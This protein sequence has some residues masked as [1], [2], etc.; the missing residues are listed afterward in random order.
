M[1]QCSK[2]FERRHKDEARSVDSGLTQVDDAISRIP[3]IQRKAKNARNSLAPINRFPPE[4]LALVAAFFESGR[5]L[6][7]ATAVCRHWRVALLSFPRLWNTIR[8]SN[9]RQFNAYLERSK[10]VPLAV[11]FYK[12]HHRQLRSLVPHTSRLV[13]LT[14][15]VSGSSDFG[16]IARHLRNSIPTLR[17]YTILGSHG[18]ERLELPSGI[19]NNHFMHVRELHLENISSLRAPLAFP[20]VT[21]LTWHV[22]PGRHGPVQLSELLGTLELLPALEKVD[23]VFW[24]SWDTGIDL[25]SRVVTLQ[26]VR[27]MCLRCS[28]DRGEGIPHILGFLE[29]PNLTSLVVDTAPRY[30]SLFPVLPFTPFRKHLP[31]LAKLPEMEVHIHEDDRIR[32]RS[33][34]QATLECRSVGGP[35]G[36]MAYRYDRQLWGG[37]PLHSVRRL[38]VTL[39]KQECG[40]ETTWLVCLLRDLGLLEHL[41]LEG[42]CG[43]ALRCLRRAMMRREILLGTKTLTVR[44][45]A[46]AIRQALRLEDV[47]DSLGLDI[48]VICIPGPEVSVIGGWLPDGDS[49]G[50]DQSD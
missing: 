9:R 19:D 50:W 17:E 44:S 42:H 48:V 23:L 20:R 16:R 35:L 43:Y 10:S 22:D 8:C 49:D 6:L 25:P 24:T 33:P 39:G 28:E 18:M 31:N 5:Q 11:Q 37:L 41:E 46:Y 36:Q 27:W 21:K 1:P 47:A 38:T 7:D 30:V 14:V 26:N 40:F 34:S 45:G 12:L 15:R 3:E 29:L 32:F 13:A 4:T 2:R